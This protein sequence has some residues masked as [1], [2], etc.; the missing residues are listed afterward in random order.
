MPRG[1]SYDRRI[2]TGASK[3]CVIENA[4]SEKYTK[5]AECNLFA[6]RALVNWE[7]GKAPGLQDERMHFI[8]QRNAAVHIARD[9]RKGHSREWTS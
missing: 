4:I 5:S 6:E 7:R 9:V 8:M 3:Q 1:Y 2:P